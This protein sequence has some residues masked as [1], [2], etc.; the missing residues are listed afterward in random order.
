MVSWVLVFPLIDQSFH[1]LDFNS[2][3]LK[4]VKTVLATTFNNHYLTN[5]NKNSPKPKLLDQIKLVAIVFSSCTQTL[6]HTTLV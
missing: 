3:L 1:V 6:Y 5:K 2:F 4:L